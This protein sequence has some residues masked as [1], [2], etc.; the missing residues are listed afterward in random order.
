MVSAEIHVQLIRF[1]RPI[2]AKRKRTTRPTIAQQLFAR[3]R[4]QS[5]WFIIVVLTPVFAFCF[6]SHS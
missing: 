1:D 5:V 4:V 6:R 2:P 3:M